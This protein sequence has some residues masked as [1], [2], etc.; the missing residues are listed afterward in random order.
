MWEAPDK[1]VWFFFGPVFLL[2]IPAIALPLGHVSQ[3]LEAVLYA[4]CIVGPVYLGVLSI[5]EGFSLLRP[6]TTRDE[7]P[8]LF[9]FEVTVG[10]FVFALM[11]CWKFA[12]ALSNVL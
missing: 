12:E 4:V 11:G 3:V 10:Y 6:S 5:R 9:W 8:V 1:R 2:A 7:W